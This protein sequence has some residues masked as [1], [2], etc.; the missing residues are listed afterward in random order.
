ME[1]ERE[2]ERERGGGEGAG[3]GGRESERENHKIYKPPR[4]ISHIKPKKSNKIRQT[5]PT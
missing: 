3:G 4:K 2:G 5:T 1:G